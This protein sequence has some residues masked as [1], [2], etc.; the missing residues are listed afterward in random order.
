MQSGYRFRDCEEDESVLRTMCTAKSGHA[1]FFVSQQRYP[2]AAPVSA[3]R[4]DPHDG[5]PGAR[6]YLY[7]CSSVP[8][9]DPAPV[10]APAPAPASAP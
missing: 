9:G 2:V 7:D 3:W 8:P 5:S 10:P 6:Y 4:F 1:D